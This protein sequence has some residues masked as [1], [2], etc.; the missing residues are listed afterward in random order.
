LAEGRGFS[1]IV[2]VHFLRH[3]KWQQDVAVVFLRMPVEAHGL[4]PALHRCG[5]ALD[6]RTGHSQSLA[7]DPLCQA[8]RVGH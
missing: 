7:R 3:N 4:L 8:S 1:K 5:F 2:E 6:Q